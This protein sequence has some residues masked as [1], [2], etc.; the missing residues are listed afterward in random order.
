M[1]SSTTAAT[2]GRTYC[3]AET[4][5]LI[6]VLQIQDLLPSNSIAATLH[7]LL[8]TNYK[9][10]QTLHPLKDGL[11]PFVQQVTKAIYACS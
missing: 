2:S 1:P 9:L 6:K 8:A 4:Q 5:E 10:L 3:D 7:P 11:L